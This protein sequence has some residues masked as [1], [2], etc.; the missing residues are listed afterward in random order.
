MSDSLLHEYPEV[1]NREPIS[2]EPLAELRA[3]YEELRQA[4]K[5]VINCLYG[6]GKPTVR[7]FDTAVHDLRRLVETGE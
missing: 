2:P 1:V 6:V 3:Q 5:R 4:A 7:D